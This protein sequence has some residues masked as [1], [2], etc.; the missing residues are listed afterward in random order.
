VHGLLAV[1]LM[2]A[3]FWMSAGTSLTVAGRTFRPRGAVGNLG[4]VVLFGCLG[5][6]LARALDRDGRSAG[7]RAPR[8]AAALAIT[9]AFGISDEIH[10]F[11]T[12]GRVPSAFD[13][14]LDGAGAVVALTLPWLRGPGRPRSWMPAAACFAAAV[15]LSFL[16]GPWRPPGDRA[17]E[18]VLTA[19]GFEPG[20]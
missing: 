16:T 4:H 18:A 15:A 7:L 2:A 8:G 19:V 5:H 12:P 17:I 10:Q 11:F 1:A 3:I 13:V 6:L 20:E 9:V 14:V